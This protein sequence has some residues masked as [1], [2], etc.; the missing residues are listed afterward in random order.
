MDARV[1]P[2]HD[3]G[4]VGLHYMA[5]FQLI[6]PG[7]TRTLSTVESNLIYGLAAV[8]CAVFVAV[9]FGLYIDGALLLYWF[10]GVVLAVSFL[11]VT[12]NP[13]RPRRGSLFGWLA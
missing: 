9:G 6:A 11:T 1:K 12:G 8:T 7:Q 10:L 4:E 13:T 2:A 5:L 3:R